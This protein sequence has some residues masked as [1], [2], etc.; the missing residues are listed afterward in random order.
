MVLYNPHTIIQLYNIDIIFPYLTQPTKVLFVAHVSLNNPQSVEPNVRQQ[1][2]FWKFG[3]YIFW[4]HIGFTREIILKGNNKIKFKSDNLWK[5]RK[6][7][8]PK[9]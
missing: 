6:A 4:K 7:R 1:A 5:L 2:K 8:P 9:F 3:W